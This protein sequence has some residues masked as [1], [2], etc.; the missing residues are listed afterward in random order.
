MNETIEK[1]GQFH[2]GTLLFQ[3][4]R[5]RIPELYFHMLR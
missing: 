3:G 1:L 4:G 5:N 2:E